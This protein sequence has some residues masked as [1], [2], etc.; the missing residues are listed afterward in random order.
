MPFQAISHLF[1]L[2]CLVW[3]HTSQ[4][5]DAYDHM[6][7]QH[8]R[9]EATQYQTVFVYL[10]QLQ[11]GHFCARLVKNEPLE[12][13]QLD[14][15]MDIQS[16]FKVGC[17]IMHFL[18]IRHLWRLVYTCVTLV[19]W[20]PQESFSFI[21]SSLIIGFNCAL[22]I[23]HSFSNFLCLLSHPETSVIILRSRK[24]W[25]HRCAQKTFCL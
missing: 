1:A 19:V 16:L 15:G 14:F 18:W 5:H 2:I 23:L 13:I 6:S 3:S 4:R 10:W 24:I 20:S 12:F 7:V 8:R 9:R 17:G 22:Y 25:R 11:L 21:Q